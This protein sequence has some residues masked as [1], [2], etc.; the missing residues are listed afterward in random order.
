MWPGSCRL[1]IRELSHEI[2]GYRIPS[3][4]NRNIVLSIIALS[5]VALIQS[6]MAVLL[7]GF[8]L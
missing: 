4:T 2:M 6:K 3:F 1:C 8:V 7:Q 5:F